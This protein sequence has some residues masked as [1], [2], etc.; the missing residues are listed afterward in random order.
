MSI[1]ITDKGAGP[2]TYTGSF[3]HPDAYQGVGGVDVPNTADAAEIFAQVATAEMLRIPFPAF[4]DGRG[5]SLAR[6]LR[7][8]GY[9]GRLRGVGH[10]LAD[11]YPHARR[12]GFDEVELSDTLAAR[13]NAADWVRVRKTSYQDRLTTS[14]SEAV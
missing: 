8:L 7:Q 12:C 13:Q 2:D 10:I 14:L 1:I 3:S 4:A 11:Q 6:R 5:F 9:Q